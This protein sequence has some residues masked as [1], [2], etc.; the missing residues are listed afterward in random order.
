M[1]LL[2]LLAVPFQGFAAAAMLPCGPHHHAQHLPDAAQRDHTAMPQHHAHAAAAPDAP[3]KQGHHTSAKC[4][5]C[6][7]CCIGAAIA[8]TTGLALA[9]DARQS[10]A[11]PF[12]AAR[13]PSVHPTLPER[14]P[15]SSLA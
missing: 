11:I 2:V 3:A 14:P 9:A 8:P 1:L 10:V 7:A 6:A 4:G 15:R 12:D 13:L 5:S